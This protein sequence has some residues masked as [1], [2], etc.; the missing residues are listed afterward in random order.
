MNYSYE[1]ATEVNLQTA[2]IETMQD[3]CLNVKEAMPEHMI[4]NLLLLLHVQ[5]ALQQ[6]VFSVP[7]PG[8]WVPNSPDTVTF[9]SG[10]D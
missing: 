6:V 3:N 1:E 7:P 4:K 9:T 8:P 10:Y 2:Y 5:H